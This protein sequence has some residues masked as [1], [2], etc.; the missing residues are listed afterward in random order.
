LVQAYRNPGSGT[1]G[2]GG[3][4]ASTSGTTT[5]STDGGLPDP[6]FYYDDYLR[7]WLESSW[8]ETS[9]TVRLYEDELKAVPAGRFVTTYPS[10]W[11]TYPYSFASK[12]EI[13]A[14]PYAGAKG[15]YESVAETDLSGHMTYASTWPG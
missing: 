12:F 6:T 10:G 5:G 4:I 11:D 14:G 9:S 7:L 8:T 2:G 15:N 13:T 1:T 3:L